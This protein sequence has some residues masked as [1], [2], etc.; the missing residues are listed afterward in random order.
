MEKTECHCVRVLFLDIDGVLNITCPASQQSG[1]FSPLHHSL[2]ARLALLC[3]EL[4]VKIVISSSWRLDQRSLR[5]LG[6]LCRTVGLL[7]E[8]EITPSISFSD[9]IMSHPDVPI[10]HL[11]S[12]RRAQEIL[13]WIEQNN[14]QTSAFVTE[15]VALD[16][17]FLEDAVPNEFCGHF[18][19]TDPSHGL[20]LICVDKIYELFEY[21][22]ASCT[23]DQRC[24]YI[25]PKR[26]FCANPLQEFAVVVVIYCL[27][28]KDKEL[29]WRTFEAAVVDPFPF[30]IESTFKPQVTRNE[31][32]I[33]L[34]DFIIQFTE[35]WETHSPSDNMYGVFL[36]MEDHHIFSR[37]QNVCDA[38]EVPLPSFLNTTPSLVINSDKVKTSCTLDEIVE[39]CQ[40]LVLTESFL[41]SFKWERHPSEIRLEVFDPDTAS[42]QLA[43]CGFNSASIQLILLDSI[44]STRLLLALEI[45][46]LNYFTAPL[47]LKICKRI[48][49]SKLRKW[50]T[51]YVARG[52]IHSNGTL[53]AICMVI[54]KIQDNN[55][56]VASIDELLR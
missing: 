10:D 15:W 56:T 19:R 49:S 48:K 45:C 13:Q 50:L 9:F 29:A 47:I 31:E 41:N 53:D 2:L 36:S 6:R 54:G 46:S 12:L 42:L 21:Q 44:L 24:E 11:A 51:E 1:K 8:F 17:L 33:S 14:E 23:R 30:T 25:L 26:V 4:H 3:E 52:E 22:R 39:C 28:I 35:W 32:E 55:T 16:D 43:N 34:R 18:V 7:D 27:P 37:L 38:Q 20:T 5:Q 40:T